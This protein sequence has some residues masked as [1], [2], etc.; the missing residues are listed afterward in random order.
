MSFQERR[1]KMVEHLKNMGYVK[2]KYVE[3]A[4]LKVKRE[5]FV[6][7]KYK[8]EAYSDTPLPIPGGVTI[9]A[10]HMHAIFMSALKLETGDKVLEVGAGSGILLAYMKEVVGGKGEVYGIE[11]IEEVYEFAKN[12]LKKA[13]YGKKVKLVLGDGSNGLPKYAPYDKIVSGASAPKIPKPWID[14]LKPGGIIVTPVGPTH[15]RQDLIY[16]EKTKKG[17]IVKK[18]LGGV[19]FVPLTGQFGYDF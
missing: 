18:N 19:V 7:D 5:Q 4:M 8:S 17:K 14:Q 12:N 9:S 2:S 1:A 3:R 11:V 10:P 13:G 6:W 15:G 16:L